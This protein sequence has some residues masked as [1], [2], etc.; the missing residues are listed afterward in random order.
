MSMNWVKIGS[1]II[2]YPLPEPMPIYYQLDPQ[3]QTSVQF[4]SNT[5]N[6]IQEY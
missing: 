3:E 1:D 4:Q 2:T 6:F 5:I